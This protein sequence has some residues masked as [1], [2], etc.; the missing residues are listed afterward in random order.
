VLA[1][2]V[3]LVLGVLTTVYTQYIY[4]GGVLY[5]WANDAAGM[6]FQMLERSMSQFV[7]DLKTP[8]GL[9]W[10]LI[11]ADNS[12]LTAAGIGLGLV[13]ACNALRLRLRWWPIHPV[14]FL[15]MGT[16]PMQRIGASF[17]V[18]WFL[19]LMITKLGGGDAYRR[20][21]PIFL[22]MIAGEFIAGILWAIVGYVYYA[23][24]DRAGPVF[25]VHP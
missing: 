7:G 24:M 18:G 21:K 20:Y 15:V 4:G 25:M 9:R 2:L 23:Y 6:P 22:G 17:L 1:A 16:M 3:A 12:F 13:L 10:D 5:Q 19:K 14:L 11:H 8:Q